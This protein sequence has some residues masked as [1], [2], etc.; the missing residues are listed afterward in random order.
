[1]VVAMATPRKRAADDEPGKKPAARKAVAAAARNKTVAPNTRSRKR[2]ADPKIAED[3]ARVRVVQWATTHGAP[4]KM[5]DGW[6]PD[7]GE[8]TQSSPIGEMLTDIAEGVHVT[9]AAKRWGIN[10]ITQLLSRCSD[11]AETAVEE[12]DW[13]Q[14]EARPFVDLH[15]AIEAREGG[16]EAEMVGVVVKKA[17][18]DA[19]TAMMFLGRRF[20]SRWREQQQILTT[21][22]VDQRDEAVSRLLQDPNLAMQL[23]EIADWVEE[24]VTND[25]AE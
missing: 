18:S 12:R 17:R 3:E 8:W 10:H 15:R 4:V 14:M 19:G 16:I 20:P 22:D 23:A 11:F 25:E 9:V 5:L 13:V 21:E 1:M 24:Q 6:N 7:T 2:K